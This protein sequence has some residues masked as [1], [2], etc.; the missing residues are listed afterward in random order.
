MKARFL[1][2]LLT[3]AT[4]TGQKA[5]AQS[6]PLKAGTSSTT[7]TGSIAICLNPKTFAEEDCTTKGVLAVPITVLSVG[8]NVSDAK[9][10]SC[11]SM[12]ETDSAF[13]VNAL[14]P[15]I[16]KNEHGVSKLT[17]YDPSTGVGDGVVTIYIAGHCN[18]A[19]FDSTGATVASTGTF[20]VVVS[21][22]GNRVDAIQ[23]TRRLF[24]VH[25]RPVA[26]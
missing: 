14:P 2:L 24:A 19:S 11:S 13:P 15:V 23:V 25:S 7:T 22:N 6:F 9:G 12:V 16:T 10:N 1:V 17:T 8:R 21:E 18:G 5:L 4:F 3:L 26:D 20:H